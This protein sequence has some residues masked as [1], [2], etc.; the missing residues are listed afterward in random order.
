MFYDFLGS[1]QDPEPDPES[2]PNNLT[3]SG[4]GSATLQRGLTKL[5]S[6]SYQISLIFEISF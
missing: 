2:D 5:Y 6:Y 4:Y 3:G 1:D